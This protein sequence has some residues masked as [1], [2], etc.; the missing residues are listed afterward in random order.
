MNWAVNYIPKARFTLSRLWGPM[1]R[2]AGFV[3]TSANSEGT[4]VNN[5][6]LPDHAFFSPMSTDSPRIPHRASTGY[7]RDSVNR[8]M[9]RIINI[10]II[11]I[12]I[13]QMA[14]INENITPLLMLYI[15]YITKTTCSFVERVVL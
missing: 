14:S 2:S 7:K 5:I 13:V 1:A 15:A 8:A 6:H 4:S 11:N 10:N 3:S 9:C 12:N